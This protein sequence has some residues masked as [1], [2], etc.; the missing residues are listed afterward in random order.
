M[1]VSLY[2]WIAEIN[3]DQYH[4]Y[5]AADIAYTLQGNICVKIID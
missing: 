4:A 3:P 2:T 5:G 1:H